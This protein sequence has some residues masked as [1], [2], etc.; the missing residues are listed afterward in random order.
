MRRLIYGRLV[1]PLRGIVRAGGKLLIRADLAGARG[2]LAGISNKRSGESK[3]ARDLDYEKYIARNQLTAKRCTQI[4]EDIRGFAKRPKIS[5]VMPVYNVDPAWLEAAIK[6]VEA[7]LYENWQLCIADDCS[8]REDTREYLKWIDNPRITVRFLARNKNIAAAT[9]AAIELADGDYLGF[10]DN[11]DTLEPDA[12]YEFVKA[13]NEDDPDVIYSDEDFIDLDG[14]RSNPHFKPD[15]C[16]DLLLS[17]N[18]ITHFLVIRREIYDRIGPLSSKYDGAQDYDLVLRATEVADRVRHIPRVLYHWRMSAQSTSMDTE[19]KPLAMVNSR[20]VLEDTLLRRNIDGEVLNANMPYFFRVKRKI[21]GSPGP[22]VS[23]VIPFR[24]RPDLLKMC[25]DSILQK[26]TYDNYEIIGISNNSESLDTFALMTGYQ[27]Q[28]DRVRFY[29]FNEPFNFSRIINF[30]ASKASGEH[31]LLLNNDIEIIT[32]EWIEAMLEHSQRPEVA[33]VGGKLFYPNNKIQ[34]AGI[35]VGIGG[36]AGHAHKHFRSGRNGYFNRINLVQ[37]VSAVTGACMMVEKRIF[38]ELGGF[39]EKYLKVACNDVDF[40]LRALEK[41][42]LNV[43]TPYAQAY[44]YESITRGYEDT[45][46]KKQRFEKEKAVFQ[47][48]HQKILASGD[49]YYN[50]NLSLDREDFSLR[51]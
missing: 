22:R 31:L 35:I 29:E 4:S 37:D 44:H 21:S 8:T 23:I 30:G 38:D 5:I 25:V 26:S 17:H 43:F 40:C 45:P 7:Q 1:P 18:Y 41:G 48:R 32:W 3:S 50:V 46:E 49:P 34:H 11:D 42:Y 6:S 14:R 20:L 13:I 24:D 27:E 47:K 39:D 28:D 10:L 2:E 36:Y 12:L 33:A 16:P 51:V 9:N 15:F 19:A